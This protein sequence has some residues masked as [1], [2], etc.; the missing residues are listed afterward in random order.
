DADYE[1]LDHL[2]RAA[3]VATR[4]YIIPSVDG[5]RAGG[6]CGIAPPASPP[7]VSHNHVE[8]HSDRP[9]RWQATGRPRVFHTARTC[10]KVCAVRCSRTARFE[11][12]VP[13]DARVHGTAA[14]RS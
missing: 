1:A 9:I 5:M 14:S 13:K 8:I 10:R 3:G 2:L 7:P 4:R 12:R 6:G 11:K